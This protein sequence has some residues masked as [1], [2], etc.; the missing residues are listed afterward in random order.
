MTK[1]GS[2]LA[3]R[4]AREAAKQESPLVK[5]SSKIDRIDEIVSESSLASME[6]SGR[7]RRA[8]ILADAVEQLS[9][10]ITPDMMGSITRLQ[11]QSL[12]FRTDR[13]EKGG[14]PPDVVKACLIEALLR[15]AY[16]V[17]NEFNIIAARPYITKEGLT[18]MVRDFPGLA[19]LKMTF[20]VPRKIADGAIVKC[21]ATWMR[22]GEADSIECEIPCRVNAGM[23]VDAILGKATRKLLARIYQRLTGSEQE[24]AEGEVG[25]PGPTAETIIAGDGTAVIDHADQPGDSHDGTQGEPAKVGIVTIGNVIHAIIEG[26]TG[27][28][29]E[30]RSAM[31]AKWCESSDIDP[32]ALAEESDGSERANAIINRAKATNWEIYIQRK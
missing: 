14:Y 2:A 30:R 16:P 5:F 24:I 15:G 28:D 23:G 17:N 11:G 8:F 29:A 25:E 12:G 27:F 31:I 26:E 9:D 6:A 4:P 21:G 3:E 20:G 22:N 18:R 1:S 32:E 19:N 13:D 7:F 10:L